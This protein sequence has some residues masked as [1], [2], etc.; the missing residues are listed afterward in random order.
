[1]GGRAQAPGD[2]LAP[3]R[4]LAAGSGV[5]LRVLEAADGKRIFIRD[6][7]NHGARGA[8]SRVIAALCDL[9]DASGAALALNAMDGDP[10]LISLYAGFGF[11]ITDADDDEGPLMV[12]RPRAAMPVADGREDALRH[13]LDG[14][15]CETDQVEPPGEKSR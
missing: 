12:R 9:A 15:I 1:M 6:I 10:F 2:R 8:G 3:V 7:Q 11:A 4:E 13:S 5:A 14:R